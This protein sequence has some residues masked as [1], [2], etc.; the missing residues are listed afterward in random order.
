[1]RFVAI[2]AWVVVL[3][4]VI[5]GCGGNNSVSAAPTPSPS[6]FQGFWAG[7]VRADD[8][9]HFNTNLTFTSGVVS[10][11]ADEQGFPVRNY[12]VSGTISDSGNLYLTGKAQGFPDLLIIGTMSLSGEGT[13]TACCIYEDGS[14]TESQGGL[15]VA[16]TIH[17][18]GV[19]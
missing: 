5:I 6:V 10:G 18:Q 9:S 1:M 2:L 4:V 8:G 16:V 17:M 12:T 19:I 15:Q 14:G 7:Y 11:T 3:A 13:S